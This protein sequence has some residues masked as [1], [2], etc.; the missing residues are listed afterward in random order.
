MDETLTTTIAAGDYVLEVV[1]YTY[2][3]GGSVNETCYNV[4]IALT[5]T[6]TAPS[7]PGPGSSTTIVQPTPDPTTSCTSS[8]ISVSGTA[9]FDLVTH[10]PSDG[11][12]L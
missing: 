10:T 9:T 6:A 8:T 4:D 5:N 12:D 11:L 2:W 3:V 1:E 7:V